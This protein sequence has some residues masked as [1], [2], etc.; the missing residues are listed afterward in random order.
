MEASA[1][2]IGTPKAVAH[3]INC[4][5]VVVSVV[6]ANC[7]TVTSLPIPLVHV[8]ILPCAALHI[9]C[10]CYSCIFGELCDRNC[11]RYSCNGIIDQTA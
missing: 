7:V 8:P 1:A 5:I 9:L 3:A 4:I 11:I 2:G 6:V 10:L